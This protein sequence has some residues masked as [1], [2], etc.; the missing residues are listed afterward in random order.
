MMELES[1]DT[2]SK[3]RAES[4]AWT[5]SGLNQP[6]TVNLMLFTDCASKTF[7]VKGGH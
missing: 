1:V 6:L 3:L 7:A 2:L 5:T 4:S